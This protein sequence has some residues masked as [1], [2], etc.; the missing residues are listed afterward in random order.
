MSEISLP[1][2]LPHN[3]D[4]FASVQILTK[5]GVLYEISPERIISERR[6]GKKVDGGQTEI[7]PRGR[8]VPCVER[9]HGTEFVANAYIPD[10]GRDGKPTNGGHVNICIENQGMWQIQGVQRIAIERRES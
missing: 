1:C 10:T 3:L 4:H 5:D 7:L 8:V 6:I 9:V 2:T